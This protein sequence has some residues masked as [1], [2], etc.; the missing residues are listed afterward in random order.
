MD[1]F[2]S[3][4][5]SNYNSIDFIKF[6]MAFCVI[7]IH[8]NPLI[9]CDSRLVLSIYDSVVELAVPFFFIV[10]GFLMAKKFDGKNNTAIIYKQMKKILKMYLLWNLI[11]SP[12][13]IYHSMSSGIPLVKEVFFYIRDFIFVGQHYNSWP[14]WYLLSSVYGFVLIYILTIKQTSTLNMFLISLGIMFISFGFDSI[15]AI[16]GLSGILYAIQRIIRISIANGRILQGLFFIPLGLILAKKELKLSYAMV[17]FVFGFLGN[18]LFNGFWGSFFLVICSVGLF[19]MILSVRL[20][21][22][23]TWIGLRKASTIIYLIHMYIWTFYYTVLY[24][25]KTYG[26]DSFLFTSLISL[27]GATIF[28]FLRHSRIQEYIKV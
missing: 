11:Y 9:N 6:L 1:N 27:L 20:S 14:L 18:C 21:Y 25:E 23:T 4:Q 13:E 19:R 16:E 8:T 7:A 26:I 24:G 17:L 5:A 28:L 15:V 3:K 12:L 22:R 2:T 10:S